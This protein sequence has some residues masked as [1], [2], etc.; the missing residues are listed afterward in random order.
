MAASHFVVNFG[1]RISPSPTEHEVVIIDSGSRGIDN[2]VPTKR[3]V[4]QNMSKLWK[5]SQQEMQA[6]PTWTRKLWANTEHT[7]EG[8]TRHL[9][10]QWNS[11]PYLTEPKML[12]TQIDSEIMAKCSIALQEFNE[13]PQGKLIEQRILGMSGGLHDD[14]TLLPLLRRLSMFVYSCCFRSVESCR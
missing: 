6:D 7:L 11:R 1:V 13:S 12:T 14:P 8:G 3:S 10:I 2:S 5:W 4:N 9:D